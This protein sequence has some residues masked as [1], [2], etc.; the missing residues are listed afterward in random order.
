MA[1]SSPENTER[2]NDARASRED[3]HGGEH[4]ARGKWIG[5][6][7]PPHE[8]TDSPVDGVGDGAE[9]DGSKVR[10]ARTGI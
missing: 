10:R 3:Q 7:D 4:G 6:T 8:V 2:R 9:S 5:E 1:G